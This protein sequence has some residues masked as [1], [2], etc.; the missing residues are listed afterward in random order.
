MEVRIKEFRKRMQWTQYELAD[1]LGCSQGLVAGWEKGKLPTCDTIESLIKL[2]MTD[3]ELFGK[4]LAEQLRTNSSH[5]HRSQ[6]K[7]IINDEDLN[8]IS[9]LVA[10]MLKEKNEL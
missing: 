8:R 2:G 9:G 6:Q 7:L 3:D 10:K 1:K 5:L 4:S